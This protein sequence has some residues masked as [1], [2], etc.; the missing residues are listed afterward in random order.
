MDRWTDNGRQRSAVSDVRWNQIITDPPGFL[1]SPAP[2]PSPAKESYQRLNFCAS[3]KCISWNSPCN[4]IV[5]GGETWPW[6]FRLGLHVL[7][8]SIPG[9]LQ[10]L[11]GSMSRSLASGHSGTAGRR[12]HRSS[13][14]WCTFLQWNLLESPEYFSGNTVL[15]MM[16]VVDV[17]K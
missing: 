2:W 4:V 6:P 9:S 10:D 13:M 17:F 7:A 11:S 3:S 8:F 1:Q 15:Y 16:E 14:L 5:S 12:N